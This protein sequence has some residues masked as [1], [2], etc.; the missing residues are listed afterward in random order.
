M[1]EKTNNPFFV[2]IP[3]TADGFKREIFSEIHL[4]NVDDTWLTT[5]EIF[6]DEFLE[7]TTQKINNW[8]AEV[9]SC[10]TK[11]RNDL[12]DKHIMYKGE[13]FYIYYYLHDVNTFNIFQSQYDK[14]FEGV[15]LKD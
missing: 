12:L 4:Y 1:S 2:G 7:K 11:S 10:I 8:E 13:V 14:F 15:R 3:I 6:C 5:L 9:Y